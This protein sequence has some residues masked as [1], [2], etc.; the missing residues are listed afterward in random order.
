L[1]SNKIDSGWIASK[2]NFPM[3]PI[4]TI[5]R[6]LMLSAVAGAL[7]SLSGVSMAQ[8]NPHVAKLSVTLNDKSHQALGAYKFAELV[9]KKSG[10][11]FKIKV[12]PNA[13]LG[14][15]V[16]V[17][18]SLQ[19]GTVEFAVPQTT[20]LASMVKEYGVLDLPYLFSD[21]NQAR[22]VL[23][24]PIG[25]TLMDKLPARGLVGLAYWENGFFNFTNSKR[26]LTRLEDFQGLK[27]RAVQAPVS[28][29]S[30]EALGANPVPLAVPEVFPALESKAVDGQ[31]TPF[32]VIEALKLN[33]VQKYLSQTKHAY[34]AFIL[35]GS[36]KFMDKLTPDE[37]AIL[38]SAAQEAAVYQRQ[39]ALDQAAK[40]LN[41]LK[42][43][44]MVYNEVAPAEIKRLREKMKP[45]YARFSK[46]FGEQLTNE[47]LSE[48][49]KAHK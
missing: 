7:L 24:G 47:L 2:E 6:R 25:K 48:V 8:V 44:G 41:E 9:E 31:G 33:E 1:L 21:E 49:E 5:S 15:D 12:F 34:G 19:G 28:I 36:K 42:Q 18:N 39:V 40:S 3:F 11:K 43:K 23:D 16:L 4:K 13:T 22:A 10:G 30:I 32:A 27:L 46:E 17:T 38:S 29:A 20:T 45:V 26:P 35:L 37:R 14:N